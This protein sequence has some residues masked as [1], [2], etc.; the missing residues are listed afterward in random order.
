MHEG[1][2]SDKI[3]QQLKEPFTLS[4]KKCIHFKSIYHILLGFSEENK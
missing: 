2:D 3:N 4:L 1:D